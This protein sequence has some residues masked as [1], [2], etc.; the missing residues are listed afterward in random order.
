MALDGTHPTILYAYGGFNV[1]LSPSYGPVTGKLW[2]NLVV[3]GLW[4][5]SVG[6]AS[7]DLL[8]TTRV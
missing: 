8:G 1:S 6:E 4:R 2:I 7:S 3:S 5:T